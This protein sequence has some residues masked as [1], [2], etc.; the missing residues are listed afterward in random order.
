ME[1]K[2]DGNTVGRI[3]YL[4]QRAKLTSH[5]PGDTCVNTHSPLFNLTTKEFHKNSQKNFNFI[6]LNMF[7]NFQ[8]FDFI[9]NSNSSEKRFDFD[10]NRTRVTALASP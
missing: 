7:F 3:F 8:Y 5:R 2:V 6:V 9:L 1:K 4:R 10:W